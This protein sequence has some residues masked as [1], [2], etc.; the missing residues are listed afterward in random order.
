M[1]EIKQ[2]REALDAHTAAWVAKVGAYDR[3]E[4]WRADGYGSVEAAI[5]DACRMD[6]SV[7]HVD[8]KLAR[9]LEQL[10]LVADAFAEGAIS[11]RHA[12]VIA[13][14][15]TPARLAEFTNLEHE[16]VD[17]ARKCPPKE[18]AGIVRYVTDALD[19][20]GGADAED[21]IYQRRRYKQSR[22]LDNTL[23][24][25]GFLDPESAGV[26][27]SAIRIARDRDERE[28]ETR[29]QAQRN[30][31]AVTMIMRQWLELTDAD[32][33][34]HVRRNFVFV[35]D[36][37]ET[38]G[39]GPELIAHARDERRRDG[40]LSEATLERIACDGNLSR[41]IMFGKSEVLDVGRT[42]R[43]ATNAQFRALIAR[44]RH[45]RAPGCNEPP[46]RC[47]AHHTRHWTRGGPTDLDNLQLLC[48]NHHRQ[49][50]IEDAKDRGG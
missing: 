20:D 38:P 22:T 28:A 4:Q 3:S 50:H 8:V 17:V 45:C 36:L 39:I 9:K 35:V 37:M 2:A 10:P 33:P 12:S 26:H 24:I 32:T 14:A 21:R 34:D 1:D 13:T 29:T 27:E 15:A 5:A 48:W 30:A 47:Q 42:T 6:R 23:A 19:G 18:L 43:T 11:R 31:D 25:D 46:N 7:V 40:H 41:I 49:R 16:F 44:D